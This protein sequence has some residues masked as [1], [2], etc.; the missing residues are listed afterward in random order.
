MLIC[1]QFILFYYMS[2]HIFWWKEYCSNSLWNIWVFFFLQYTVTK[3]SSCCSPWGRKESDTTER[4]PFHF[5]LSC[6]GEGSGN[7]LQ[8]SCLEN[9]RDGGAWWAAIYGV[10]QSR[11]RLKRH[12]SSSRFLQ[13]NTRKS[14]TICTCLDFRG[15]FLLGIPLSFNQFWVQ[16][17][18]EVGV[19]ERI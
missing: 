9:P 8:C 2:N 13:G 15:S 11:T 3:L 4:L 6:I 7:P 5:S 12:S 16:K 17:L 19:L 10:A 14:K 1:H 18:T